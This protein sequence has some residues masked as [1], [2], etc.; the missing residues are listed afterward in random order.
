MTQRLDRPLT[1]IA[2]FNGPVAVGRFPDGTLI[3]AGP[4][5]Q[6]VLIR[7]GAVMRINPEAP[8]QM[9]GD[10]VFSYEGVLAALR[11]G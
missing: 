3:V 11:G 2:T 6:P 8:G 10:L 1:K 7:N 4:Q 9:D 5:D